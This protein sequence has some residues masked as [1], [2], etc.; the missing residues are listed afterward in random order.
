MIQVPRRAAERFRAAVRRCV[1]GR[2]RGFAPSIVLTQTSK[3]LTM[4]AAVGEVILSLR[5]PV[6]ETADDRVVLSFT[7]L[8]AI[9]RAEG[10]IVT[11][12]VSKG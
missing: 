4:S 5:L 7:T 8:E 11:I 1:N 6:A 3:L 2:P 9:A 10:E 12:D